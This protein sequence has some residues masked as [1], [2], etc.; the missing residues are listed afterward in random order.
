ME[1]ASVC[2]P[3]P[4]QT[5]FFFLAVLCLVWYPPAPTFWCVS[6]LKGVGRGGGFIQPSS[7]FTSENSIDFSTHDC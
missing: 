5:V 1:E 6:L 7:H 2:R 3:F 4:V